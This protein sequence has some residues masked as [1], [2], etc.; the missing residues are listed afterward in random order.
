M[1]DHAIALPEL[2]THGQHVRARTGDV[3]W[4]RSQAAEIE[5]HQKRVD[6]HPAYI[7]AAQEPEED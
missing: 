5:G 4:S 2:Q 1:S 6:A 7:R 3:E